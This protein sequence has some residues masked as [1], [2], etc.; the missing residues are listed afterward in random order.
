MS[1]SRIITVRVRPHARRTRI[2][3]TISDG[4]IKIALAAPAEDGKANAE[5][6]RFL[7]ATFNVPQYCIEILSGRTSRRK[8]IKI[9][10]P[11]IP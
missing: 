4:I 9:T 10:V 6:I 1:D 7:S 11:S 3:E 8:I 2:I 5:L